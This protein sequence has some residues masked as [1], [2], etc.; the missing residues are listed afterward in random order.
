MNCWGVVPKM[1]LVSSIQIFLRHSASTGGREVDTSVQQVLETHVQRA[2]ANRIVPASLTP[3][4]LPAC[5]PN[6]VLLAN[7]KRAT[8]KE[9]CST[10]KEG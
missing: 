5:A 10:C 1:R 9:E 2:L 3:S 7:Q 4:R 8:K 6:V